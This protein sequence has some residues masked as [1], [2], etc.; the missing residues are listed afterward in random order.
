M[1]KLTKIL[2][3]VAFAVF[4]IQVIVKSISNDAFTNNSLFYL[5][6]F[7]ILIGVGWGIQYLKKNFSA[8]YLIEHYKRPAPLVLMAIGLLAMLFSV[9]QGNISLP[10]FLIGSYG[11]FSFIFVFE[12]RLS[13]LM[14]MVL[15]AY[16]AIMSM[17]GRS[18]VAEQLATYVIYFL[19]IIL[20][21]QIRE[22]HLIKNEKNE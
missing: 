1:N 11:L 15:M 14:A 3:W 6:S 17:M 22:H 8:Q 12:S 9:W 13:V 20:A 4:L 21:T 2:L 7:I 18:D 5:A 10:S 16:A 19:V